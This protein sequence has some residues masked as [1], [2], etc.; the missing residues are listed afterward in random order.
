MNRWRALCPLLLALMTAACVAANSEREPPRPGARELSS[1]EKRHAAESYVQAGFGH[2]RTR[3]Y[4]TA[5]QRFERALTLLPDYYLAHMAMG[6]LYDS[7]ENWDAA[8]AAFQQALRH[9]PDDT[10]VLNNYGQF[11]CRRGKVALSKELLFRAANDHFNKQAEV[12]YTN[13]AVCLINQ[14][15]HAE[16][17]EYLLQAVRGAPNFAPAL[18]PLA[19]LLY[20]RGQTQEARDYLQRYEANAAH[21]PVSLLL[22]VQIEQRLGDQDTIETYKFLLRKKFPDS[23]QARQLRS[24]KF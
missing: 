13:L 24:M 23:E 12:S 20:E 15:H 6:I 21:S 3:N 16:A 22:G 2:L 10:D 1:E 7:T 9:A 5:R 8:D 18:L 19:K 11:L 4:Q 14:D 17:E